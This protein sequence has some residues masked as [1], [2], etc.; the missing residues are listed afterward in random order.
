MLPQYND[1]FSLKRLKR[2]DALTNITQ[3]LWHTKLQQYLC[4][5]SMTVTKIQ[6]ASHCL[7]QSIIHQCCHRLQSL[8]KHLASV[9]MGSAR[10]FYSSA[11]TQYYS[12]YGEHKDFCTWEV[13]TLDVYRTIQ[14][15][16]VPVHA[17]WIPHK[18]QRKK[19]WML[20]CMPYCGGILA[21]RAEYI[22]KW[23]A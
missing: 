10:N 12:C 18:V 1:R 2:P 9:I 21:S 16:T 17:S 11:W 5:E 22:S 15:H 6:N 3:L 7:H 19:N 20:P 14:A 13:W 8:V 4:Y 23:S